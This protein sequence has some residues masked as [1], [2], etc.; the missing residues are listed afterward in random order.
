MIGINLKMI[1]FL[2]SFSFLLCSKRSQDNVALISNPEKGIYLD[3]LTKKID[4]IEDL[5]IKEK[6]NDIN[7]QF[8]KTFSINIDKEGNIYILDSGNNRIQKYD[9][10][11]NHIIT[12]GRKGKGPGELEEAQSLNV[13][14]DLLFISDYRNSRITIFDLDGNYVRQIRSSIFTPFMLIG[15]MYHRNDHIFY[16]FKNTSTAGFIKNSILKYN[17]ENKRITTIFYRDKNFTFK[18]SY[19][20]FST[21][22][23][24]VFDIDKDNNLYYGFSDKYEITKQD[25]IGNILLKF[26]RKYKPPGVLK[27]IKRRIREF[28]V[29][30][31]EDV[32]IPKRMPFFRKMLIYK[33]KIFISLWERNEKGRYAVDVFNT[34]G[35]FL[36]TEY[37]D[38]DFYD[39]RVMKKGYAYLLTRPH[40]ERTQEIRRYKVVLGY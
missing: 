22:D 6:E 9:K 29:R 20:F 14:N 35:I 3:I 33:D 30:L 25:T 26:G 21:N 16:F 17:T 10:D 4:F 31:G 5:I 8:S 7:Y 13:L 36:K 40:P 38:F 15:K 1:I 23:V 19:G 18:E 39:I 24:A 11:G 12:I 32:K 37:Y 2:I 34:D 27:D 28:N